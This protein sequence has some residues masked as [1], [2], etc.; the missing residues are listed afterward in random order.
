M[1]RFGAVIVRINNPILRR[2]LKE[3]EN[4]CPDVGCLMENKCYDIEY[5]DLLYINHLDGCPRSLD[6]LKDYILDLINDL[7]DK[8]SFDV[9]AN[10]FSNKCSEITRGYS[11]VQWIYTPQGKNHEMPDSFVFTYGEDNSHNA[12]QVSTLK[13]RISSYVHGGNIA[14]GF[15]QD[16][17]DSFLEEFEGETYFK[18]WDE[19][20]FYRDNPEKK[21]DFEDESWDIVDVD[22]CIRFEKYVEVDAINKVIIRL[23]RDYG[24]HITCKF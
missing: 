23:R 3:Y 12:Q 9:F 18:V 17:Y 21:V 11:Y 1:Q 19:N 16:L 22:I 13:V 2:L 5:G 7:S 8:E 10:E 14:A 6:D 20:Y 24:Y 15:R 4:V